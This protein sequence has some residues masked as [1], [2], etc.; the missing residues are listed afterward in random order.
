MA[1]YDKIAK[2]YAI[3]QGKRP[4]KVFI[5]DPSFLRVLGN[6]MGKDILDIGCGEGYYTRKIKNSGAKEVVGIDLSKEVISLAENEE[7]TNPRG[8]HYFVY[9]I[10]KM[11]KL[12]EFDIVSA[13]LVIHYAKTKKELLLICKNVYKNLKYGGRL[14]AI[15]NSPL[16][17]LT[18]N[19][20]YGSTVEGKIP[21]KE[22]DKLKVTLWLNE[23]PS[24]SFF[25]YYWSKETY[26]DCL[27]R[28]GF[29]LVN[30]HQ[31]NVSKEGIK[32]FGKDFWKE[33]N[34]N[35][36]LTIIEAIK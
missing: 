36:Y 9:N 21:L 10:S 35:R 25:N 32:K 26:E 8:I 30:W 1:E 7:K 5:Y 31:M 18:T 27:K 17:P 33:W 23:K 22:G 24:C 15:N 4:G 28:A 34:K 3:I 19:R 13:T 14:I 29:K 20:K 2:E 16:D 6:V 11:P 12:G